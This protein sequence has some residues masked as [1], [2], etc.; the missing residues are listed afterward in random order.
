M[1]KKAYMQFRSPRKAWNSYN[2]TEKDK[3]SHVAL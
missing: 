1:V 2:A 3:G